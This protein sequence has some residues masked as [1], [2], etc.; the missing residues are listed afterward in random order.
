MGLDVHAMLVVGLP[1]NKVLRVETIN[2]C[3]IKYNEDTGKPYKKWNTVKIVTI[4]GRQFPVDENFNL[5]SALTTIHPD[6]KCFRYSSEKWEDLDCDR[7]I[8][9]EVKEMG[10][11]CEE[12]TRRIVSQ[13]EID[14]AREEFKLR[15]GLEPQLFLTMCYSY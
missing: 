14:D 12:Q 6:L 1:T 13:S 3:V 10:G 4:F 9:F 5:D 15:V 11:R 7:V 8:G 2:T